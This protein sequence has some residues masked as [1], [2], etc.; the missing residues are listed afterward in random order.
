MNMCRTF[1]IATL[2]LYVAASASI[3]VEPEVEVEMP[4]GE[5]LPIYSNELQ[6]L[7]GYMQASCIDRVYF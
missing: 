5:V 7:L 2:L 4:D 1:A 6:L 3:A